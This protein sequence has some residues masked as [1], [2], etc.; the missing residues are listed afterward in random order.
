M[1]H[2]NCNWYLIKINW[3]PTKRTLSHATR[4]IATSLAHRY[5]WKCLFSRENRWGGMEEV[6]WTS[7]NAFNCCWWLLPANWTNLNAAMLA[8]CW[9]MVTKG[10]TAG[11]V[12]IAVSMLSCETV[13]KFVWRFH[14]LER[15]E[16]KNEAGEDLSAAAI[17]KA[18]C[19]LLFFL[20]F[21]GCCADRA[22]HSLPN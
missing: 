7:D 17:V 19:C 16:G 1:Y 13:C 2:D 3:S 20:S 4:D 6:F 5:T 10:P 22:P 9:W 15:S 18:L 12:V 8:I 11:I 21:V 14:K